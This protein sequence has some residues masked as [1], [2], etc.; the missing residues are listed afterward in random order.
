VTQGLANGIIKGAT[1]AGLP[2]REVIPWKMEQLSTLIMNSTTMKQVTSSRP[3]VKQSQ[4]STMPIKRTAPTN[5]WCVSSGGGQLIPGFEEALGE[6]KKGKET[7]VVIAP[8]DAYGEKDAS[9]IETISIDKLIRAV[10]DPNSLYI[11]APVTIGN[12]QGHL[13]YLAAGRARIDYNHP[14]A[15]KSLKYSFKVVD[16]VEGKE[17]QVVALLQ[18]N[19]GHSGFEVSFDG[20]D[21]MVVLPQT[22]LFD[23]NAAMLK[24]RLV[25]TIRDA[26]ECG[27]VSFIEVHEPRGFGVQDDEEGEDEVEDLSSLSVAELKERCKAAGLPVG[28]KKADLVARLSQEEE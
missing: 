21:L 9:Q 26:V 14:M 7:E 5:Q 12:R 20:D 18:A 6:A 3:P 27:K 16:V 28:G 25:T 17:D 24:F 19:T 11:G 4:K 22:M 15:G 1:V 23:T 8:A 10:Q 2:E 13:S